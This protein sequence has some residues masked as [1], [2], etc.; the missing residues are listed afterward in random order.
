MVYKLYLNQ[1]EKENKKPLWRLEEDRLEGIKL[2]EAAAG[3]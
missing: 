3:V 1:A 2:E